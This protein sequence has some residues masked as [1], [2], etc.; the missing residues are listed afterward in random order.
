MS[1]VS[2]SSAAGS[3]HRSKARK[4]LAEVA[5]QVDAAGSQKGGNRAVQMQVVP[6]G[7][8]CRICGAKDTDPDPVFASEYHAWGYK[9][10]N[11]K[12]QGML[13]FYC[14]R[15]INARFDTFSVKALVGKLGSDKAFH[16]KFFELRS[17][18]IQHFIDSGSR[19]LSIDWGEKSQVLEASKSR[20]L[21]LEEP[22]D[23]IWDPKDY[24]VKFGDWRT[25]GLGHKK[26]TE[27][28]VTGIKV[29][30]PRVWKI[31]RARTA[32]TK[33]TETKDIG[34]FPMGE[35]QLEERFTELGEHILGSFQRAT[36]MSLDALF[37]C[38][39]SSSSSQPT[40]PRAAGQPPA[41]CNQGGE[42]D[43]DDALLKRPCLGIGT[44]GGLSTV[45]AVAKSEDSPAK[46]QEN[47]KP[48]VTPR[49]K[50]RS[51]TSAPLGFP[52][53]TPPTST[54]GGGD[55]KRGKGRPKRDL[56][57]HMQILVKE[58]AECGPGEK[59]F[60]STNKNHRRL[61]ERAEKDINAA[62]VSDGKD[63]QLANE[64]AK[65]QATAMSDI[66][67]AYMKT[68]AIDAAA[69]NTIEATM[70]FLSLEPKVPDQI[71]PKFIQVACTRFKA[72]T[73]P[74]AKSFWEIVEEQDPSEKAQMI[75]EK[76]V[77]V[78]KDA[79][80]DAKRSLQVLCAARPALDPA[81]DRQLQHLALLALPEQYG[82]NEI[83]Q[84]VA[85]T[86]DSDLVISNSLAL[87]PNGRAIIASASQ[88]IL[89]RK[90]G[91]K[92]ID[93]LRHCLEALEVCLEKLGVSVPWATDAANDTVGK[94]E[95]LSG[96][97]AGVP[98]KLSAVVQDATGQRLQ[99][100][101]EKCFRIVGKLFEHIV[102]VF[103]ANNGEID[104]CL[105]TDMV[106]VADACGS[107]AP[108]ASIPA[109]INFLTECEDPL[110]SFVSFV[111]AV[112]DFVRVSVQGEN[113]N[114]EAATAAL[115]QLK[116]ASWNTPLKT[117][118]EDKCFQGCE[119]YV[120]GLLNSEKAKHIM[121]LVKQE[122]SS[123]LDGVIKTM[124]QLDLNKNNFILQSSPALY[125]QVKDALGGDEE[126][127]KSIQ[128]AQ[129]WA[130]RLGDVILQRQLAL[131]IHVFPLLKSSCEL[132]QWSHA[133]T[134]RQARSLNEDVAALVKPVRIALNS[135]K[136]MI[137]ATLTGAG[138]TLDN[139]D[140]AM[141]HQSANSY[142]I[143]ILDSHMVTGLQVKAIS[144]QVEEFLAGLYTA[145]A[146]DA[147][148]LRA[149][150]VGACPTW[151]Q[152]RDNL[153]DD[154][155]EVKEVEKAM[156]NNDKFANIG[157]ATGHLEVLL[158]SS[159]DI[160][161][162]K[163][164]PI[165]SAPVWNSCADMV[166][167]ARDTTCATYALYHLRVVFPKLKGSKHKVAQAK[168]LKEDL[169]AKG[170]RVPAPLQKAIEQ[171][172]AGEAH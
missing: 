90:Q 166:K 31:K 128:K 123:S 47:P 167:H 165:I 114:I 91:A 66:T 73:A 140:A 151:A 77:V 82:D 131:W 134:S 44:G 75:A 4:T 76:V 78:T 14:V 74:D 46:Q 63:T 146:E 158:E 70:H 51:E 116:R 130:A 97:V 42:V 145:W 120:A 92:H 135:Y 81:V 71:L 101:L 161:K 80:M 64:I 172:I 155:D 60:S 152:V 121:D 54:G 25:N 85:A 136:G 11:G 147:E 105:M 107:L 126:W 18:C 29:P 36:G 137:Q 59:F 57:Q 102:G 106:R 8:A 86:S 169:A 96:E 110:K 40:G 94:L 9:P 24:E 49:K 139:F 111:S 171:L 32:E 33:L 98:E 28:G 108:S 20:T 95:K 89:D 23:Q 141:N 41:D 56:T 160:A 5:S 162:D 87:W 50:N 52:A 43:E 48:K 153:L 93:V 39:G 1:C 30:G 119:Q 83:E 113:S 27:E 124:Q 103:I 21:S 12:N 122:L 37:S 88:V 13:D 115:L 16:A 148:T 127:Q 58:F 170:E 22:E 138:T 168:K 15:T 159:K 34:S 7:R 132:A 67:R 143:D 117:H 65:K 6:D 55:V 68:E 144:T 19:N 45:V 118:L 69:V 100:A 99:N 3:S 72:Q 104:A 112:T 53:Q 133:A 154:T 109:V 163:L 142:H 157:P 35:G 125:K 26:V 156:L 79:Q 150:L 10:H 2:S 129:V 62:Q 149:L 84:A 61:L 17:K 38:P 164:G